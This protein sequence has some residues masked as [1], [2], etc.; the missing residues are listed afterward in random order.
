VVLVVGASDSS[1]D[2]TWFRDD[3]RGV[4]L[5]EEVGV[6]FLPREAADDFLWAAE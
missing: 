6:D 2:L 4:V 3:F 5:A 1:S